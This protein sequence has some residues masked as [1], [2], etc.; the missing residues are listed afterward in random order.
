MLRALI[1]VSFAVC[2]AIAYTRSP[3]LPCHRL[4]E[5]RSRAEDADMGEE[6]VKKGSVMRICVKSQSCMTADSTHERLEHSGLGRV[7]LS[8]RT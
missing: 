8:M 7:R 4:K 3:G 6:E 2:C 1:S 5:V